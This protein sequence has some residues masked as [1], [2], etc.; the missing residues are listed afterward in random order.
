MHHL[1]GADVWYR[2]P[3][4]RYLVP[5]TA[6]EHPCICGCCMAS[7]DQHVFI[8]GCSSGLA[9]SIHFYAL[10]NPCQ[11]DVDN[12][13]VLVPQPEQHP[14]ISLYMHLCI[15]FSTV[16]YRRDCR[17]ICFSTV[18]YRQDCRIIGLPTV[19]YR[20]DCRIIVFQTLSTAGTVES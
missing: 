18:F 2:L 15:G 4:T 14:C 20:R 19:F 8:S 12:T 3:C 13:F 10:R 7:G 16:F 1:C 9:E 17:I 11:L 5:S 6:G